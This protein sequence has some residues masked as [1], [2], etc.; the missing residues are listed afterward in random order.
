MNRNDTESII[1]D[2]LKLWQKQF[3]HISRDGDSIDK[4]LE[5]LSKIQQ[6]YANL[7]DGKTG[8][9]NAESSATANIL[10]N[11]GNE[12]VKLA[13]SYD[14]LEERVAR[15][16]SGHKKG[17]DAPAKKTPGAKSAGTTKRAAKTN[18]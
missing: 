13:R 18:K 7:M 11:I 8:T 14:E 15:L 16:E 12:F 1:K 9:K 6:A 2:F 4:T 5:T 17:G 10:R 3:A